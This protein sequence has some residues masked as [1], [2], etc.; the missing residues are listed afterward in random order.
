MTRFI[1]ISI[2][3]NVLFLLFACN[4]VPNND[5]SDTLP[6]NTA[7]LMI[8]DKNV[9]L[10]TAVSADYIPFIDDITTGSVQLAAEIESKSNT[11]LHLKALAVVPAGSNE[12]APLW[13]SEAGSKSLSE[14]S[15]AFYRPFTENSYRFEGT[16]IHRLNVG[17]TIIFASQLRDWILISTKSRAVESGVR[18][19]MGSQNRMIMPENRSE[20]GL[21]IN[22]PGMDKLLLKNASVRYRPMLEGAFSGFTSAMLSSEISE[23]SS[24]S[25]FRFSGDLDIAH[26]NSRFMRNAT[27]SPASF[28][29]DRAVPSDA[30]FFAMFQAEKPRFLDQ[31]D[32]ITPVSALDSL[33][34]DQHGLMR[35][36]EQTLHPETAVAGFYT[37]GFSPVE[38]NIYIRRVTDRDR[39]RQTLRELARDEHI[40]EVNNFY[41]V[42]S[43]ILAQ[44]LGSEL[45]PYTDF[46][47][48]QTDNLVMLAPRSGLIQRV[49]TDRERRRVMFYQDEYGDI[50]SQSPSE[51]SMFLYAESI[52]FNQFIQPFLD[53]QANISPYLSQFDAVTVSLTA[54]SGRNTA[55][56][57]ILSHPLERV[58]RPFTD[59]WFFPMSEG[60]EITGTPVFANLVSPNRTNVL[61]SSNNN[62][63]TALAS[64]G[65]ELFTVGTQQDLP[66]GS[67]L[68]YDW[69]GNNQ[70][71]ILIAAGNKIYGWNNRGESLPNFPLELDEPISAP[72]HIADV[73]RNGQPEIIVATADRNLHV[74][75]QRGQNISGW[76]QRTNST[77]RTEP[78]FKL[79]NNRWSILAFAENAL[80]GWDSSGSTRSGFPLF[81]EAPLN[82]KP[83]VHESAVFAGGADGNLYSFSTSP[84]FADTLSLSVGGNGSGD[85]MV[86]SISVSANPLT[87]ASVQSI[88]M[89]DEDGFRNTRPRIVAQSQAGS[90][91]VYDLSG[92]LKFTGNMGQPPADGHLPVVADLNRDNRPEI[93]TVAA[94]GRIYAWTLE[95]EERFYALP[96]NAVQYPVTGRLTGNQVSLVAKTRE[97]LRSWVIQN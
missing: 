87:V 68:I 94:F 41:L 59:Q 95:N 43:N 9:P 26:K 64:D 83:V 71:E 45:C 72:I 46:Y 60:T 53:P 28:S 12:F 57:N 44:I 22:T 90:V 63:I 36:I 31:P 75:N 96:S 88:T 23:A 17:G 42:R 6:E 37:S 78:V 62:R 19:Y 81:G 66:V 35:R 34:T 20:T 86:L 58:S 14:I 79:L 80:F 3:L 15:P 93:F 10:S 48:R 85:F 11:R 1:R 52:V 89:R 8:Q 92:T 73:S 61:I 24:G 32:D 50:R 55:S 67:P 13:I 65:T 25:T 38:E 77:I 70:N 97:G 69:Y 2:Y 39:L 40:L 54:D 56:L 7:F 76:P 84:V 47:V 5:W 4:R 33:L 51:T 30:A 74:L 49:I 16:T 27:A 18:S 29:L 21:V 91:F 82:G